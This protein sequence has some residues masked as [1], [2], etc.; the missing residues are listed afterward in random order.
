M[1]LQSILSVGARRARPA[2]G[3]KSRR[4]E[5]AATSINQIAPD[6]SRA[7]G[8]V[9]ADAPEFKLR[10]CKSFDS[11]HIHGAAQ[12][13]RGKPFTRGMPWARRDFRPTPA[14]SP[15]DFSASSKA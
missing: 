2:A 5:D 3:R 9:A 10:R 1:Y 13:R 6:L 15:P 4:A 7:V 12:I 14:L 8:V 11:C